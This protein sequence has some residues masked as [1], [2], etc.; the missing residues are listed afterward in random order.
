MSPRR[1]S[2]VV[3]RWR[4]GEEIDR[5]LQSLLRHRGRDLERVVLVDSGSAD[6]GAER[7]AAA[8]PDVVVVALDS[9]RSFAF[10]AN[11]GVARTDS[12]CLLLLNP[13]A[14]VTD[15][16][17]D[18]L[19]GALAKRPDA[20]GVVPLLVGVDGAPQHRW[21]LR[22]LPG[23]LRLATGRGGASQFHGR[24]PTEPALVEQPAA[25]AWLV[26]R[27]VWDALG[28]FDE[29]FAPAWWEDVDFCARLRR[30]RQDTGAPATGFW[31]VP[32][33]RVAHG[34]GSSLSHLADAEFL[35]AFYR[36]LLRYAERHHPG[37]CTAIRAIL[38]LSLRSRALLRPSRRAA[39]LAAT[40]V[41]GDR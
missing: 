6:G 25:A 31:V 18:A 9:N 16:A 15:G 1:A 29:S 24:P 22:R 7:L 28:G 40:T 19:T 8:F 4:G 5:C 21:Q 20:A 33:A 37:S 2:A 27:A 14:E 30:H 35:A 26:R 32:G 13:D 11:Q 10:A 23:P 41:I 12:P 17:V 3:V 39:Y 38:L 36:N 34:G